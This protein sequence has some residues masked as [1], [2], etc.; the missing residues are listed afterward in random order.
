MLQ[1]NSNLYGSSMKPFLSGVLLLIAFALAAVPATP[2]SAATVASPAGVL[3]VDFELR[4]G[5]PHYS[6][7]RFDEVVIESSRLGLDLAD[8]PSLAEGLELLDQRKRSVDE[9]WTQPWGETAE[10]RNHFNELAVDLGR[11]GQRLVTIVFRV[12]DEGL[13]FR[14][15]VAENDQRD[16]RRVVNERSQFALTGDHT[17][18]WTGAYLPNRYEYL[19]RRGPVS[20]I[21]KAV[22]PL[23]M[24]TVDGLYLSFHEAALVDYSEMTLQHVGDN[25]L[26]ADLVPWSD[27]TKVKTQGAFVTP[28]RTLQVTDTAA[29]LIETADIFLNLNEP[30]KLGDVSWIETGKYVGIWWALHIGKSTWGSGDKHGATTHGATTKNTRR[31]IDFAAEH[32][33]NGVLVEGWNVGWDGDWIGNAEAFDF[34]TPYPDYDIDELARYAENKGVRLIGH[35]E[36]SGGIEN[37]ERQLEDAMAFMQDH[38]VRNIKTGYVRENGRIR[39]HEDGELELEWQHG[40]YMVDHMQRV[41]EVAAEHRIAI[42]THEPVKDTGLRRTYPNWLTREGQRGQEYNAWSEGNGPAHTTILP[43]TRMLSGPMDF[44]PGI[45][46]LGSEAARTERNI[47]T[48]LAKQLALYVVIYSPLQ[49]AADLPE[50]YEAKPD[51]FQFIKDVPAD[52]EFTRAL[53]GEIGEFVVIARK[54]RASDDWYLGAITD[55]HGRA[56]TARL[57]FLAAGIAYTAEVYRDAAEAHWDDNPEA[58][59]IESTTVTSNDTLD[60][61]LAPGGG[62]AIRFT[63]V[64]ESQ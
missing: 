35:H 3:A 5:A 13:G 54:D 31:Y 36:T 2:V 9:T 38:G 16:E 62:T 61:R 37:Y 7:R 51:P 32:G 39:R 14:Y 29:R 60:L 57:G 24:K 27:G 17:A 41:L 18:W 6:V 63:P 1:D 55:E 56:L 21:W 25:V 8:E 53:D 26:Q 49:M 10:V 47:P 50:N 52:W 40:Q 64:A 34:T 15:E 58:I 48:T 44:T 23:T 28:W 46:D 45:F 43:F 11:D 30:N 59:V 12:F 22:T 42:N 33:F 19:Y 4:D 20:A